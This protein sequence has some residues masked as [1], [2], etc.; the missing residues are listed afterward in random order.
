M[1]IVKLSAG[2][3]RRLSVFFTCLVLAAFAWLLTTLSNPNKYNIKRVLTYKNAPQKRAFHS[4]QS[5]SVDITI[6]GNGWQMLFSRMNDDKTPVTVDLRSLDNGNF[7]VL[8]SQLRQINDK[9][10]NHEILAINPDT[11]YFDFSYRMVKRVPVHLVASLKYQQQFAQSNNP[12]IKPAFVTLTGPANRI[13]KITQWDTDSLIADNVNET[14]RTK[15]NMQSVSEGNMSL[16][17]KAVDVV[18]PV[19]EYTEKTLEIPVKLI[20]NHDYYNVKIFPQKVKLTFITSLKKYAETD[21]KFFEAE[22]DLDLWKLQGYNTL[23]VKLIRYPPF[24]KIVSIDPPNID[25]II[26]K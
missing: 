8:S 23:P 18:L 17:P 11:L 25:F 16:Y 20:N 12:I 19:D 4:L 14:I 6:E 3:R 22:S 2:E 9:D 26:K 15:L 7:V 1:A 5:D 13:S 10:V 24:C 21:E